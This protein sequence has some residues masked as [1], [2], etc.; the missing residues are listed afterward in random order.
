[1]QLKSGTICVALGL[2]AV[3]SAKEPVAIAW[4]AFR[5][6]GG[7]TRLE[8]YLGLDRSALDWQDDGDHRVAQAALVVM[9]MRRGAIIAFKELQVVDRRPQAPGRIPKQAT[10]TLK[11][12]KYDLQVVAEDRRGSLVDTTLALEITRWGRRGIQFSSLVPAYTISPN[13]IKSEFTRQGLMVL[14]NAAAGFE[15]NS[16]LWYYAELYGL[17]PQDNILLETIVTR[18]SQEAS[19]GEPRM[20]G[21]AALMLREWGAVNL[22]GYEPGAYQ[23]E[24]RAT[25]NDDTVLAG[26]EFQVLPVDTTGDSSRVYIDLAPGLAAVWPRFDLNRYEKA[27]SAIQ[28]Q[29]LARTISRLARTVERDS[30]TYLEQ[31]ATHWPLA[32][33]NDPGWGGAG[34]LSESGRVIL[35][36]GLP[37]AIQRYP[38]SGSRGAYQ[39][40]DY[41]AAG[42][43][44][45]IVFS[46]N[47]NVG[48]GRET[49]V[50]GTL[51]GTPFDA[52]WQGILPTRFAAAPAGPVL[53]PAG[54]SLETA[55]GDSTA[56]DA[57]IVEPLEQPADTTAIDTTTIEPEEQDQPQPTAPVS[58]PT[59]LPADSTAGE[60][61]AAFEPGSQDSSRVDTTG[62][63]PAIEDTLTTD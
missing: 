62:P 44:G 59:A 15:H 14:P 50:H 18:D 49:L 36:F 46:D 12:G 37:T 63:E 10:F 1:M 48:R 7:Q 5:A 4:G 51:P 2:L 35:L 55:V 6:S 17:T 33:Q 39:V 26:A 45:V 38:A 52:G 56:T 34:H 25:V 32:R 21:S 13:T 27:D 58:E 11:P 3:L 8:V 28:V 29:L 40:W 30:A 43:G 31:L 24:L 61:G 47:D 9:V 19:I 60:T 16:L 22:T 57:A 42:S 41:T 23:L 53:P 54:D 20:F